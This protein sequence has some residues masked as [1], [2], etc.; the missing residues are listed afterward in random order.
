MIEEINKISILNSRKDKE[1]N[2]APSVNHNFNTSY[3]KFPKNA[4]NPIK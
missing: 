2:K 3:H 4:Q 1:N